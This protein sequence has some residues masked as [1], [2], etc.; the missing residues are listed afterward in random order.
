MPS[1]LPDVRIIEVSPRDGLQNEA[2]VIPL[3]AKRQL[4]LDLLAAGAREIEVGSFVA[5][6]WVPQMADTP[7]LLTSLAGTRGLEDI[8]LVPNLK[9]LERALEAGTRRIAI[10][11]AAT[12]SFSQKNL[13]A[14][15]DGS[16][17]RFTAVARRALDAGVAVRGYISVAFHCPFEGW[18]DPAASLGLMD[19]L[20]DIGCYEVSVCDTTGFATPGHVIKLF[21][22][23]LDR[24]GQ[25]RI[26]AHF[27]DTYAQ[28]LANALQ[29]W[30]VGVTA[31]DASAGGLGGCPYSP[32]ATGNIATESL[33]HM[34][35]GLGV[36][37][38]YDRDGLVAAARAIAAYLGR[39]LTGGF[40]RAG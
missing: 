25:G 21:E 7:E 4:V 28:G 2:A 1:R 36:A 37:T 32:G 10:F 18:V 12:E 40:M 33:V 23:A 27:H 26:V 31:F 34:F 19:R 11:P 6:R 5:P 14:T 35:E 20:L 16:L 30:A 24:H 17:A 13:N 15:M 38:G 3:S 9:G 39:P 8:S 22:P 29:A